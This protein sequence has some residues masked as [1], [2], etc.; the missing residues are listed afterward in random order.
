ME[1][2]TA[3]LCVLA[4]VHLNV[5][6]ERSQLLVINPFGQCIMRISFALC[7][8]SHRKRTCLH[9]PLLMRGSPSWNFPEKSLLNSFRLCLSH[10]FLRRTLLF[11]ANP[12]EIS[13]S[14]VRRAKISLG[15][16]DDLGFA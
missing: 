12:V 7:T 14:E 5:F 8:K 9:C 11:F 10:A 6:A 2:G 13:T 15:Q 3:V 1:A 4:W 16:E